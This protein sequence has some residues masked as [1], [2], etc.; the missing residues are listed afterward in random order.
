MLHHKSDHFA[1]A[2]PAFGDC[3]SAD[4]LIAKHGQLVR[5]IA[6]NVR[7]RMA[8]SA[9]LEDLMQIGLI[10]LVDAGRSYQDQGF[11]FTTYATTRVRGAMIDHLRRESP[12]SRTAMAQQRQLNIVRARLEQQLMRTPDSMELA[13]EM[14]LDVVRYHEIAGQCAAIE[15]DSLDDRYSDHDGCFADGDILADARI[16]EAQR[17]EMLAAAI[18]GLPEKEAWI[19]QLFFV[20]ELNLHEIGSLLGVGAARIC[21]IKK[22]ALAKL[23]IQLSDAL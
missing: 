7:S 4:E 5:R 1:N 8:N 9:E 10:A 12:T 20:E 17:S 15:Q 13:A 22:S 23:R 2:V 18:A 3:H 6:W 11:A 19:L 21:Q 14:G 16:E